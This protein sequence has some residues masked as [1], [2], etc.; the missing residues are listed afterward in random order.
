MVFVS[1][2]SHKRD[3]FS[4]TGFVP[5]I[6]KLGAQAAIA[7]ACGCWAISGNI[8]EDIRKPIV[9]AV[10]ETKFCGYTRGEIWC[11][12]NSEMLRKPDGSKFRCVSTRRFR[13]ET[14]KLEMDAL[15]RV[16]VALS[17]T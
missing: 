5:F 15:F 7:H 14:C 6:G 1:L 12:R 17:L 16:S 3:Q 9:C 2:I 4:L 8:N 10:R 13:R 11:F